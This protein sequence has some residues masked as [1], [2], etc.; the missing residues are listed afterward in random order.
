MKEF[1]RAY[2]R[3]SEKYHGRFAMVHELRAFSL[4]DLDRFIENEMI[5][6]NL[7]GK[8]GDPSRLSSDQLKDSFKGSDGETYIAVTMR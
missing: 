6:G 1:K 4:K 7:A 5:A 3:A 8:Y 2:E